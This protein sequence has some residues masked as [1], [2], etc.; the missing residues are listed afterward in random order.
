M[1]GPRAAGRGLI[2]DTVRALFDPTTLP[3]Q[4]RIGL[5]AAA[6]GVAV[7]I[8]A[9]TWIVATVWERHR[10]RRS[11]LKTATP[12]ERALW[13]RRCFVPSIAPPPPQRPVGHVGARG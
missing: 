3:G 6:F 4:G 1:R 7:V 10:A 2:I 11:F 12:L 13:E 5:A 8:A 9:A